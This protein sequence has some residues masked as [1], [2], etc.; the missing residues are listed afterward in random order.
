MV[1]AT[2]H[3]EVVEEL[4]E[5]KFTI[6][7]RRVGTVIEEKW[8]KVGVPYQVRIQYD[9]GNKGGSIALIALSFLRK[10]K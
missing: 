8:E 4:K 5:K 1:D 9:E 2:C 7:T 3:L 10:D 6:T